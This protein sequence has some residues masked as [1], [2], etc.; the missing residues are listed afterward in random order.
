VGKGIQKWSEAVIEK[1]EQQGYGSGNG[2]AYKPWVGAHDVASTGRMHRSF[3]QIFD[4]TIQMLSDVEWNTFLLL[5][6]SRKFTQVYEGFPLERKWTLQI[7]E[8]LGIQHPHYERTHV[9]A[10]MTVDFLAVRENQDD[11]LLVAFDCKRSEDAEDER[12]IEKLQITRAYFAGRGVAHHLVFHSA[13]P[14]SKV[15]NI[16]WMR[17][18]TLKEGEIEPYNGYFREK[19]SQMAYEL[20]TG[21]HSTPLNEYCA[22][23]EFRHQMRQGDG[24]RVARI[25]LWEHTLKCDISNP[26][27]QSAPMNSFICTVD[28]GVPR[29]A[30]L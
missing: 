23:F 14:M 15:K 25:L 3:S 2:A 16:E 10:V 22:S 1:R 6:H 5:E 18:A 26:N 12:T 8:A 30:A 4:R 7:A 19:A 11:T 21:K 20:S 27:L 13:L 9:P 24:L 29:T 28:V 17:A